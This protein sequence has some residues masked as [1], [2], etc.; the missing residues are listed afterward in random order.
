MYG[1]GRSYAIVKE[2][3]NFEIAIKDKFGNICFGAKDVLI[4]LMEKLEVNLECPQA[5]VESPDAKVSVE[6]K[7]TS[8]GKLLCSYYTPETPGFCRLHLMYDGKPLPGTPFSVRTLSRDEYEAYKSN[9][10]LGRNSVEKPSES[11]DQIH[12]GEDEIT[13]VLH[14][15]Q[16]KP[17]KD[18]SAVWNRIAAVAYAAD[19]ATEGWDSDE[20]T[21]KPKSSEDEYMQKHP[22]VPVVENLE[23]LWLVSK[24]QNERK[25]KEEEEKKRRLE[26][27][28]A[29][30]EAK[31]G[32]GEAP[33]GEEETMQALKEI[34]ENDRKACLEE[35]SLVDKDAASIQGN[36]KF[37]HSREKCSIRTKKTRA[38]L[39]SFAET[40]N[41]IA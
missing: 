1:S 15:P 24:L 23:D 8:E 40:L 39:L 35:K 22:D 10:A 3:A 4:K 12:D 11:N 19:G 18:E 31:Y 13:A 14:N 28:Q 5:L 20:D 25:M 32:P 17:I 21:D 2:E 38:E 41:Q 9:N 33:P 27:L 34:V 29:D 26:A 30:L 16:E 6:V 7:A 36:D 37:I